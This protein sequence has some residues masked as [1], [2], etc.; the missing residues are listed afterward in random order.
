MCGPFFSLFRKLSNSD[1]YFIE[2]ITNNFS[3]FHVDLIINKIYTA[4]RGGKQMFPQH[5]ERRMEK[6]HIKTVSK[7]QPKW[8]KQLQRFCVTEEPVKRPS[9]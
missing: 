9:Q 2:N 1:P 8:L 3:I 4:Y 5:L 7:H 6:W